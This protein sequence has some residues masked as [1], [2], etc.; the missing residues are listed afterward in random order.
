[1]WSYITWEGLPVK[2]CGRL[3]VG[4]GPVSHCDYFCLG[5]FFK[6]LFLTLNM[7]QHVGHLWELSVP[8]DLGRG[9]NC[10]TWECNFG[11]ETHLDLAL[12]WAR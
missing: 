5:I 4:D 1:M 6:L 8:R 3:V 12:L 9:K 11:V 7:G 2:G 10:F